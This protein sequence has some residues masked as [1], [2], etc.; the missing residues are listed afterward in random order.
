VRRGSII[1]LAALAAIAAAI[2]I[3]VA[4]AIPWLPEAAGK[5]AQRIDFVFWFT[6]AI[7]IGVFSAVAAVI[8]YSVW[9][10]R[11]G[12]DDDSDGPPIHGHTTLE[13]VWT[14]IP[15]ILVTAISIVSAIVLAQDSN[16]GSNPVKIGVLGRQFAWTF[17]Y[18]NGKSLGYLELPVNRKV[19]LDITAADVIHSF[20][21]PQLS[22]KQD[23]VPGQHNKLVITPIK[24][25]TF[26]VI[27]TELCGLGH[28][29]MRSHVTIVSQA[30]FASFLKS[31]GTSTG[32]PPGLAVF[33]KNG[34]G[35]C[36]TFKPAG[37]SG[38]IGPDLDKL[39]AYAAQAHRGSLTNFIKESIV[40]PG[41]YIAPGFQNQ[42]PAIF[43]QQIPASQLDQLV[44]YLAQNA[45]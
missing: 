20:W 25:G 4:L 1:Q 7:C 11:A 36:H 2:C 22:Q 5:E 6:T 24:T 31:G 17:T 34:C 29:L 15:A 10:F 13:I 41:A 42:M 26:P 16:A 9:K 27:C 12:P 32:G 23:A 14:A 45:H 44:Q 33:N 37:S 19:Q 38:T 40:T 3:A 8:A 35:S 43:G 18:S 21:V 30:A 28:S 39:K